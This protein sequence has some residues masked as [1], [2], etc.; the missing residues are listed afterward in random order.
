MNY[1]TVPRPR[2]TP[3]TTVDGRGYLPRMRLHARLPSVCLLVACLARVATAEPQSILDRERLLAE[4][5]KPAALAL[6]PNVKPVGDPKTVRMRIYASADY[7][8]QTVQWEKHL[9]RLVSELNEAMA[10][11]PHARFEIVDIR[12]WEQ[13]SALLPLPQLLQRLEEVDH[14][15]DVDWV[16]GMSAAP[17]AA[18]THLHDLGFTKTGGHHI[19]LRNLHDAT[20]GQLVLSELGELPRNELEALIAMRKRHKEAVAFLHQW[21]H[22]LGLVDV[23]T[24]DSIMNPLYQLTQ[25]GFSAAEARTIEGHSTNK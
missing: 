20:E 21:G 10:D 8:L 11:W 19:V 17:I 5:K 15:T 16:V 25:T 12:R 4:T 14:G 18:S 2:Q 23:K 6:Q 3:L 24:S 9:R 1:I 13:P 7:R 22:S